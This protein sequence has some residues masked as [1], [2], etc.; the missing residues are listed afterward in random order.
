MLY[1]LYH[2]KHA[3]QKGTV[4]DYKTFAYTDKISE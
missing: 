1:V 3:K 2:F 4:A